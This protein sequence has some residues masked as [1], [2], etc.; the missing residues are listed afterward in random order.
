MNGI[1]LIMGWLVLIPVWWIL[2]DAIGTIDRTTGWIVNNWILL[3]P[4]LI[5]LMM[6][7]LTAWYF[8]VR[9]R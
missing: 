6:V 2:I 1:K 3:I 5:T 8:R 4:I 9:R 7:G